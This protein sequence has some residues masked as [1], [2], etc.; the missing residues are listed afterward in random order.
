MKIEISKQ[1]IDDI[2]N[3]IATDARKAITGKI[4]QIEDNEL[5]SQIRAGQG[6]H[7]QKVVAYFTYT[8]LNRYISGGRTVVIVENGE[9][10]KSL[11]L[12]VLAMKGVRD[13]LVQRG[14]AVVYRDINR[15]K[16][17]YFLP[18][19]ATATGTGTKQ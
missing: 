11:G 19:P 8:K 9:L 6:N 18:E 17:R 13:E 5:I 1:V 3:T 10:A 2:A 4:L 16:I 15:L 7:F 12:H 14:S